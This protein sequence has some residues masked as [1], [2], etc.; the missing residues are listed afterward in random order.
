MADHDGNITTA[1]INRVFSFGGNTDLRWG[2]HVTTGR[3]VGAKGTLTKGKDGPK[4]VAT[5]LAELFHQLRTILIEDGR[6]ELEAINDALEHGIGGH[7]STGVEL[8][9][10]ERAGQRRGLRWRSRFLSPT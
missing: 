9:E 3:R 7:Y 6:D 2:L 1:E 10:E 5:S 8:I 4:L